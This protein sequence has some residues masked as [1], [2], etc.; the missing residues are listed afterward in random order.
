MIKIKKFNSRNRFLNFLLSIV[1]FII[2]LL[3]GIINFFL[4]ISNGFA[5][6]FIK[7]YKYKYEYLYIIVISIISI[8]FSIISMCGFKNATKI[9]WISNSPFIIHVILLI[10]SVSILLTSIILL[11]NKNDKDKNSFWITRIT[12]YVITS[13]LLCYLLDITLFDFIN[14]LDYVTRPNENTSS[15][16]TIVYFIKTYRVNF[17]DG[18]IMTLKLSLLG[19]L[20]GLLIAFVLVIFRMF[21][22]TPKDNIISASFKKIASS[23]SKIYITIIRGT[24]MVVQAFIFY[25]LFLMIFQKT[26]SNTDYQYFIHNIWTPYRAGLFTVT[27]NTAAYLTEVLRGGINSVDK[28]QSEAAKA[29][30]LNEVQTMV[31][32]VFPQAIKS[33]LPSIGNE[34]IVNIKD[35]SVLSLIG[36]LDLFSVGKNDILG[37]F[38]TKSLEAYLIVAIYYLVLTYITS[39]ILQYIEKKMEIPV[40]EI[41]SSN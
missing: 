39:K 30:G 23:F 37:V 35:T 32:I 19:T 28:G 25:Y 41:T 12:S 38:T 9:S 27:I 34:F 5:N 33:S 31:R 26:L 7:K 16:D 14:R 1:N 22:I 13:I 2:S 8:F 11:F 3:V 36:I 20:F 21:K 29:L 10:I 18:I 4:Y 15:L 6:L 40:K 24:P 17:E